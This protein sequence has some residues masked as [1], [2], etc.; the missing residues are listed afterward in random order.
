MGNASYVKIDFFKMYPRGG[1]QLTTVGSKNGHY[2]RV[3]HKILGIYESVTFSKNR[4]TILPNR[5][6]KKDRTRLKDFIQVSMSRRS[7]DFKFTYQDPILE[8]VL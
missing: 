3:Q 5:Y 2:H 7:N 4:L 1:A 6:L 8:G